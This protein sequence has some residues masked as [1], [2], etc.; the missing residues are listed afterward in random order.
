MN[1]VLRN[2]IILF[3]FWHEKV[4]QGYINEL[5]PTRIRGEPLRT[6]M[7]NIYRHQQTINQY[8]IKSTTP[9]EIQQTIEQQWKCA[10]SNT[11]F[12]VWHVLCISVDLVIFIRVF[13]SCLQSGVS[14]VG[15]IPSGLPTPHIWRLSPALGVQCTGKCVELIY[16]ENIVFSCLL[17]HHKCSLLTM[18][19]IF[20]DF[21]CGRFYNDCGLCGRNI[22]C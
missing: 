20:R 1:Y 15:L 7:D 11:L 13:L 17:L 8:K 2:K 4:F 21:V 22:Y 9:I 18:Y 16:H 10:I 14:L 19:F 12:W 5:C 6:P 3:I